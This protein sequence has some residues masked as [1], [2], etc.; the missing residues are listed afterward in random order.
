MFQALRRI[1]EIPEL[2]A[3]IFTTLVL[4]AVCR[5]GAY[6]PVPGI[7]ADL[8]IRLFKFASGGGQNLFQLVDIFSGGAFAKMTIL[9]LGV[10]PY[11]TASIIMQLL[12][13][14]VPSMQREIR[15]SPDQGRRKLSKWTRLAT[16]FISLMQSGLFAS[17]VIRVNQSSPGIIVPE[18]LDVSL[19][20]VS[21][22]FYLTV[23]ITMTAG[24]LFLMWV[25]E[26][27]SERG[28][29]NGISLIIAVGILAS[30]PSTIGSIISQLNLG[31]QEVGQLSF[32]TLFVLCGLFVLIT[33]GT[34]LVIQGQRRIPLQYARRIVGRHEVQGGN[35]H[36]PLK[37]NYAGVIPVI[38]AS[39]FLMPPATIGQF[40]G[41]GTWLG[42]LS[43][44]L[45]PGNWVYTIIYVMLILFF[46][47]F[48][49]STQF[50]PEQIASDMKKNGAFIPGVRQGKPTQDFLE[51]TMSRIT[52]AGAVFL[53]T[54]AILPSLVGKFLGVDANISQFFGGTSLLILVGV[55]LDTTKQVE[56]H[57]LMKRYE[58][59][60]SKGR[61]KGR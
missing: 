51:S 19:F 28:I 22:L 26:Q 20:G 31:S 8:A 50:K 36:I 40:L 59:F 9:A 27:I 56:S 52:L 42:Q 16:L 37:I 17:Y 47:Y 1:F 46:T 2:R 7:H 12:I 25:G 44:Y 29:G 6:I 24:T 58:G 30:F 48:W 3:K 60:M 18:I 57:L 21:W 38:F 5:V 4:L 33:V 23:M 41:R 32:P 49:T 15:E 35:S 54:I 34:I 13:A 61:L 10:M 11:I 45:S 14:I 55:I 43:N 39:A 53:A